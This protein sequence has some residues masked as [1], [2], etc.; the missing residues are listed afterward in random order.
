[1]ANSLNDLVSANEQLAS[2]LQGAVQLIRQEGRAVRARI[3]SARRSGA[4]GAVECAINSLI[5]ATEQQMQA[6]ARATARVVTALADLRR[7]DEVDARGELPQLKSRLDA[8]LARQ[9]ELQ[10]TNEALAGAARQLEQQIA[11]LE[12]QNGAVELARRALE[13]Q[14]MQLGLA[15][16]HKS[17]FLANMSHELRTPLNTIL[18]L[19]QE[20]AANPEANLTER[21]VEFARVIHSSG[22]DLLA[23]ITDMLDLSKIESGTVTLEHEEVLFTDLRVILERNFRHQSE[24]RGLSFT[25]DLDPSLP[26]AITSDSR[27]LLQILRNLVSNAVKFTDRGGVRVK[28]CL[29]REGWSADHPILGQSAAVVAFAVSDTGIGIPPERQRIIFEPFQQAEAGIARK[30]GGTGLGLAIGRKLAELL[31]GEIG[32]SS[33]PGAGSTFTLYLPLTR[34]RAAGGLSSDEAPLSR[35]PAVRDQRATPGRPAEPRSNESDAPL[36]GRKVLIVDDDIRSVFALNS[37]LER[38]GM[39]VVSATSGAQAIELIRSDADIALVLMDIMMPEMDGYETLRRIRKGP[40]FSGL[41]IIVLTAR[42]MTGERERCLAAGGSD[43]VAKPVSQD[44]LLALLRR[45]LTP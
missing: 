12:R 36:Q 34:M 31:G 41:P 19:G 23:L 10:Q 27:R 26:A 25:V 14:L 15:S 1:V 43:C 33:L 37:V 9:L 18:I 32:L 30:Y 20:L 29:A 28:V 7:S 42:A 24:A 17:Q 45:W 35:G 21:Q 16:R 39:R 38:H 5:D 11:E 40:R 3:P 6:L 8:V 44:A 4:W 22:V 2:E 13:E